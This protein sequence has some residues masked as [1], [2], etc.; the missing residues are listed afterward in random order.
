MPRSMDRR[1][2]LSGTGMCV[3]VRCGAAAPAGTD[4]VDGPAPYVDPVRENCEVEREPCMLG[5]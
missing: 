3:A 5:L 2:S 1:P 4:N